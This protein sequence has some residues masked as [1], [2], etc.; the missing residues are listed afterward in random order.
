M[1]FRSYLNELKGCGNDA[2][3]NVFFGGYYYKMDDVE[4]FER[5]H[6]IVALLEREYGITPPKKVNVDIEEEREDASK[7]EPGQ[8]AAGKDKTTRE[9]WKEYLQTAVMMAVHCVEEGGSYTK[10]ELDEMTH[11]LGREALTEEAMQAFRLP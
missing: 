6:D 10:P 9:R 2:K 3:I 5:R 4:S 8:L 11:S 7:C 1:L